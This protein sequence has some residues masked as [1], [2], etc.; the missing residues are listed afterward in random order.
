MLYSTLILFV[1]ES[2][3]V[4]GKDQ[5][6][7]HA[8][9]CEWALGKR[10]VEAEMGRWRRPKMRNSSG[11]LILSQQEEESAISPLMLTLPKLFSFVF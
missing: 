5:A 2:E 3:S 7:G 9:P 1:S 8:K 10:I 6:N 11:I 4:R